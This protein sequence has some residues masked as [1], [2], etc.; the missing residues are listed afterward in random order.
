MIHWI[1]LK[2]VSDGLPTL[3]VYIYKILAILSLGA[4]IKQQFV[5][6]SYN[7]NAFEFDIN[8]ICYYSF[9]YCTV[10]ENM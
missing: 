8:F 1:A 4:N 7:T 10:L 2:A 6:V 9:L 3:A 5:I